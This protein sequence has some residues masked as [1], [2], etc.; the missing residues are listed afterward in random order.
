ML[1][2]NSELTAERIS[3][4]KANGDQDSEAGRICETTSESFWL[5]D[6]NIILSAVS[7]KEHKDESGQSYRQDILFRVHK[8][9]LA[10]QS[11]VF[12]DMF[13]LPNTGMSTDGA[14]HS[15]DRLYEGVPVISMPDSAE[16]IVCILEALYEPWAL[17]FK[18]YDPNNP[19]KVTGVLSMATKYHLDA[20]R[21]R[22]VS[23]VCSDWPTTLEEWDIFEGH[24][25]TLIDMPY[26]YCNSVEVT[27][28][29]VSAIVL[30]RRFNIPEILPAAFYTLSR[31]KMKDE[32][33]RKPGYPTSDSA[34][35]ARWKLLSAS[36]FRALCR[37]REELEDQVLP[38]YNSFSYRHPPAQCPPYC[39]TTF[40]KRVE[41]FLDDARQSHD[42]LFAL[43][44]E[45][46]EAG[47][48]CSACSALYTCQAHD[49]RL[50]IWHMLPEIFRLD[51]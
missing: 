37:G 20:V 15:T 42:I 49:C 10:R 33:D 23:H 21:Q 2:E 13:D 4:W 9:L 17:P 19:E 16:D 14:G 50:R 36:D 38:M 22:V 31:L 39:K 18:K 25:F 8:S 28:E 3:K 11:K 29:P 5:E 1:K 44:T 35:K 41:L 24:V 46:L 7:H 48:I 30:A 43:A 40:E 26:L 6:G 45:R 34:R 47:P 27:P 12:R 51:S 32:Y